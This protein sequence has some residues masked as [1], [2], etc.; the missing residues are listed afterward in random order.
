[1]GSKE[2][3]TPADYFR[4]RWDVH[5]FTVDA[6]ASEA[7][8]LLRAHDTDCLGSYLEAGRLC[9]E[10]YFPHPVGRYY[11]AETNGLLR[12]HY[13][14]GDRVWCNPPYDVT[15]RRWVEL[16]LA[17]AR[18]GILWELL[19]PA[20]PAGWFKDL[21]WNN[22]AG[23]WRDGVEAHYVGRIQFLL[24]GKPIVNKKTGKVQSSR[25]ENL[26]V[27]LHPEAFA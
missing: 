6:A 23:H 27:T 8:A 10:C 25:Q 12:E 9:E 17:C 11:T 4:E 26:L 13:V 2:Y 3:E 21:L 22:H 18:D 5:H 20:N 14:E 15:I 16:G 24:D 19:L 1:M 7:N